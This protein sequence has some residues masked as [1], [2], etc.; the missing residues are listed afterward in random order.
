MNKHT[1]LIK[2]GIQHIKRNGS[3]LLCP[4][5]TRN[6]VPTE[7]IRGFDII[8]LGCNSDCPLFELIKEKD[9][10]NYTVTLNCSHSSYSIC[11]VTPDEPEQLP[12]SSLIKL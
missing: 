6:A 12:G 2:D 7:N 1:I 8:Q 11:D 4:F 10:E 9:P 5:K 3:P